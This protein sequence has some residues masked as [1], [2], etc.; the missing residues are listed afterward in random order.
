[1]MGCMTTPPRSPAATVLMI[2]AALWLV[3]F[4]AMW[5]PYYVAGVEGQLLL[6]PLAYLIHVIVFVLA[7]V[8]IVAAARALRRDDDDRQQLVIM[9]AVV[10]ILLGPIV[11]W[12]GGALRP[13]G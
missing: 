11:L 13:Q 4:A 6:Y 5:G 7:V 12:F 10:L 2:A 1:M 9:G 3:I 8:A